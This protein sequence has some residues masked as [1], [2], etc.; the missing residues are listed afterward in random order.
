MKHY[1]NAGGWYSQPGFWFSATF[2]FGS[3]AHQ[4][5]NG[6]A[7]LAF[8][9]AYKTAVLPWQLFKQI[10]IPAK[11]Q[12]G[13]GICFHHPQNIMVAPTSS[14]GA[15]CTLYHEV[16]VGRGPTPGVPHIGDNVIIYA[17][18][19]ILGGIKIGDNVEI[20][21]NTVVTRDVPSNSVV[22]A[23]SARAIPRETVQ[24]IGKRSVGDGG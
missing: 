5:K 17:G 6:P 23:P 10:D 4:I 24:R 21:A 8:L 1:Q 13:E 7:R 20:G 14:I 16:T 15:N 11:T 18:A 19:K 9:A 22:S 2:R 12:I 3:W